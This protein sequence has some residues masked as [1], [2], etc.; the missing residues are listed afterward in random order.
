M[1]LVKDVDYTVELSGLP[2]EAPAEGESVQATATFKGKGGL[3]ATVA[4]ADL[5]TCTFNVVNPASVDTSTLL[6]GSFV[7]R[8]MGANSGLRTFTY[9][10]KPIKPG[11]V[12]MGADGQPL[13]EGV[14]YLIAYS[15][16]VNPGIARMTIVGIGLFT[17]TLESLFRIV[18]PAAQNVAAPSNGSDASVA[19][20][21]A[22]MQAAA[23]PGA[24]TMSYQATEAASSDDDQS[25][26]EMMAAATAAQASKARVAAAEAAASQTTTVRKVT[27]AVGAALSVVESDTS[28]PAAAP[29]TTVG[30]VC[31]KVEEMLAVK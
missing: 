1:H 8:G 12:L 6:D 18:A 31:A 22:S 5:L 19:T 26:V 10:G 11:I 4:D 25:I 9:T 28:T 24:N 15:N 21:E 14:D 2:T 3:S 7:T 27:A 16:N 13:V 29:G 17:G 30:T 20:T 23:Q